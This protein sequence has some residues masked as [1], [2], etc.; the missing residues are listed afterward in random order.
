[1]SLPQATPKRSLRVHVWVPELVLKRGGIQTFSRCLIEAL[2]EILGSDSVQVMAKNDPQETIG[3]EARG[4][5]KEQTGETGTV[6][7]SRGTLAASPFA[8]G[9]SAVAVRGW[10]GYPVGLRTLIFFFGIMWRAMRDRPDLVISTHLNFGI[11]GYVLKILTRTPYWC[12]AHGVEA[13]NLHRRL[14]RL[15]LLKSDLILAVSNYTRERLLKEQPLEPERVV[16]LPNTIDPE[17]IK[18]GPKPDYLMRRHALTVRDKVILTVARLAEPERYKGYDQ[19]L[20]ALPVIRQEVPDLKY[21]LVGEGE[22]R[23]RIE[24]LIRQLNI[25]DAVILAGGVPQKELGDYYNLCDVFAMPSKGEGFGIV[26]LEALVCGKPVLAGDS[27]GSSEPLQNG[28]LGTLVNADDVAQIATQIVAILREQGAG[29]AG[30]AV[31]TGESLREQTL[32][33]FGFE[34]FR[35]RVAELLREQGGGGKSLEQGARSEEHKQQGAGST[36]RGAKRDKFRGS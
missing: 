22:D 28:E 6:L 23:T 1:M 27:D 3:K 18:P 33:K 24:A 7:T 36:E 30:Q 2:V 26:Y 21:V 13:W 19:V 11:A 14:A 5:G 8:L 16:V 34:R 35:E 15:G 17:T 29:S 4:K 25:C 9:A 12:V 31:R 20:R 32:E 10:G